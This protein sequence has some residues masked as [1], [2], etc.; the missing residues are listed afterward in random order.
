M[1]FKILKALDV[2]GLQVFDPI[3]RLVCG[4]N[5]P[6]QL[7]KIGLFIGVP[8]LTFLI[9]LGLW[10][11]LAPRH[12]TKAGEVPTP[13]VVK[14]AAD[15]IWTFHVWENQKAKDFQLSGA[16]REKALA[17]VESRIA[18][19]KPLAAAAGEELSALEAKSKAQIDEQVGPLQDEYRELRSASR[20]EANAREDALMA[21]ADALPAGNAAA[22]E[23]FL[24]K[25]AAHEQQVAADRET[26]RAFKEKIDAAYAE[27]FPELEAVRSQYNTYE[28]E[29]QYLS[30]RL[31]YLTAGN[32]SVK[33]DQENSKL[34]ELEAQF[35]TAEG[36]KA[37]LAAASAV[38][39]QQE[40]MQ[41]IASSS[42]SRPWTFP[43]Q[44]ARSVWCVFVGFFIGTAIAIPLGVLCGLSRVIM[45]ALTP[46][47]ALFKPVSP[48]VWLPIVFIIVGGF[49]TNPEDAPV[50]P[51][52][53]S[54]AIT[55]ALCS[56]WPTLVNTALGVASVEKDHV[57]VARVLRL[58]FF[59]RLFKIVLPASLPLIFAG[60]R[61]SLGV[62]WMV[63]IAAEL[64][65]SSEG[66]GKFVWDMFNNGSSQT[67]AQMFV[68][69]FVVGAV[70][71]LLDRIMIVLQRS[72]S[73]D[74]AP[75]A[76]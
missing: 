62:G 57:N 46:L 34:N 68:V 10:S 72:V 43:R 32:Q 4:E 39:K 54:S 65:S 3:V 50:H 11:Y 49:I 38:L 31:D 2:A 17:E 61:I 12:T 30:K 14:D 29:L 18:E 15:G 76:I 71:L 41:R 22:R 70:G 74:G 36:G 27:K 5:P 24:E 23:D 63:L 6:E 45:A 59:S 35:I 64:L 44:I 48:I 1:K 21:E 13:G 26:M 52:F 16:Q 7:R 25:V 53:L 8:I 67:F 42:Y 9:F 47:I 73:F 66:I 51:A 56:L 60:L 33:L 19:L 75:T 69:V 58:G 20:A 28:E 37:T 55:V 40:S